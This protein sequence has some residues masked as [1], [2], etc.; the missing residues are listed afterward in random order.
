MV[1]KALR[2]SPVECAS[3]AAHS[4]GIYS[5]DCEDGYHFHCSGVV[6]LVSLHFP[7]FNDGVLL[8]IFSTG[9]SICSRDEYC[10][11]PLQTD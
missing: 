2:D 1:S 3:V 9:N 10:V 4:P 8:G 5:R 11:L 6:G 7:F